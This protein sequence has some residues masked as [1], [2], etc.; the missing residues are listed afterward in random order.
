[1]RSGVPDRRSE[2]CWNVACQC[3]GAAG[4][5]ELFVG[6]W[7]ATGQ[8]SHL[9]CARALAADLIG[10]ATDHGGGY[11]WYQAYRRFR[12]SCIPSRNY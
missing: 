12:I 6:L 10:R 4:L 9:E 1:M 7:A 8:E 5:I 2:G 3:C 11:R